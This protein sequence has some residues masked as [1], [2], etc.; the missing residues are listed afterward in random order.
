L[1]NKN[2][3]GQQF[4]RCPTFR[5]SI[6]ERLWVNLLSFP[7]L[8]IEISGI[9]SCPT[10][11]LTFNQGVPIFDHLGEVLGVHYHLLRLL[12]AHAVVPVVFVVTFFL[13]V[14]A[15]VF[16]WYLTFYGLIV[17]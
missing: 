15:Q 12:G 14:S 10:K 17:F 2:V 3:V 1:Q 13:G 11:G 9:T 6:K 5:N 8:T 4:Y 16:W 7:Y